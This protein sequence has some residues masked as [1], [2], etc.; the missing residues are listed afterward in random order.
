LGQADAA[1]QEEIERR[2]QEETKPAASA[3]LR[4]TQM[5]NLIL[6]DPTEFNAFFTKQLAFWG[7]VV[8]DNN[9]RA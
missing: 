8:R 1:S 6:S 9:I 2:Y 7:K 4:E 5:M 3:K